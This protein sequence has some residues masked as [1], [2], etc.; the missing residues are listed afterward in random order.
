MLAQTDVTASYIGDVTW[1][2][3]GGGHSHSSSNHQESNGIGWWNNQTLP[4]GWHA[5]AAP[6]TTGG[7]G[8]SWTPGF[9]GA[10]V[11]MG[12][13]MVLPAGEYTLSFEAFACNATNSSDPATLPAA[14][15]A[16][17]FLTGESNIDITNTAAAGDATFHTAS[18]TF[19]VATDNTAYEFGIKKLADDSKIDWC[20]IK[21]VTLTLN[22]TDK[23]AIPNNDIASFTYS[24]SQTWHTNT[25]STEGQSDGSRFQVPFHELWVASGSKLADATITGS[26]TPTTTGVYKISAWVRAVNELG[27]AVTGV[28]IFVGDAESDA[29]S[30]SS[31]MDGKGRLGTYT[32]MA[33]GV[34]GTPIEYGFKI[35]DA[36]VNWLAFKN[37]V[38]TYLGS[39]PTDEVNALLDA[40]PTG[41][42]NADVQTALTTAVSNLTS[43]QSVANYN[44]LSTAISNA[45]ASI[46]IY[47][48]VAGYNT[49]V[50]GLSTEAQGV[51]ADMLTAYTNGTITDLAPA[52]TAYEYAVN[53]DKFVFE[54]NRA[55]ALGVDAATVNVYSTTNSAE[56]IA[57][58]KSLM[59]DEYSSVTTNYSYA[60]DL[61]TWTTTNAVERNGQHWDGTDGSKY[62]EQNVG[63]GDD[64]WS[65]S[66]TQDLSL[67]AGKYVFKVAGRKSFDDASLT[68]VVSN[69]GTELG[70]VSD[71]PNGDTGLGINTSGA[72]DFDPADAYA[73]S[74]NGRGWQWRY[75]QFELAEPATVT[76]AINGS[77]TKKYN[78]VGFCNATVQTDN[79]ANVELM[80]ALV[81]LNS[82]KTAATLTK[83]TANVGTGVFKYDGTTNESLWSAYSTAKS[84]ADAYTLTSSSTASEVN[85]LAVALNTAITN[86]NNQTLNAPADTRYNV[87]IVEAGKD[88]NG[89]AI[90]FIEGGRADQGLYGV[91]YYTAAN[92]NYNQAL[93]FTATGTPDTY[94]ISALRPDGTEQYLT[95]G[96]TY[97]GN[98]DQIR[99]TNDASAAMLV[100]I[101]A[102]ATDG[103]FQLYNVAAGKVI[104]NN[105][106]ND[107]Y[108]ANSASF[109]IAE[110]TQASAILKANAGKFG[111]FIAPFAVTI[112]TGIEA[113]KVTTVTDGKLTLEAVTTT[114]PANTAVVVKNTSG[115]DYNETKQGWGTAKAD[116]YVTELL[117]GVYTA[118]DIPVSD[119]TTTNYVLQTD[120]DT[121]AFY[122]VDG[123]FIATPNR[124]Y[125]TVTTGGGAKAR[126]LYFDEA[127]AIENLT[128]K[129]EATEGTIYNLNGQRVNTLQ[130]GINIVGGTKVLVK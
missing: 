118:A 81:A 91:Q 90:T 59:V 127:T 98:N 92:A 126:V 125:L 27:G 16:V 14:G 95:T 84:N 38:I 110:A 114:I 18:F 39:L 72:T 8:E 108:T 115:S 29:C 13:T 111:T 60:V 2:V 69:G 43:V 6:N 25:W 19:T 103:Q 5:F 11:M 57:N 61:G 80:E 3:N 53:Y 70:T 122:V 63:W 7:A 12:R 89:N 113:Y 47:S 15:D 65:C 112:P 32:A 107:M 35:K 54:K 116:S 105:N 74:N 40:V 128:E 44:A 109:T 17:A 83:R 82:A 31:V 71:F 26:Y 45:N 101:I 68:L 49:A 102:T 41:K 93:K 86:Y 34:D 88:W 36:E 76:V 42:M 50:A 121:Q 106:N 4:S 62:S 96:T 30:G 120:G 119:G 123:A 117:T 20:Q 73:N 37:V 67:P 78:W 51:Y 24:G 66:Y 1:I 75:V 85:A 55:L 52:T 28:K 104:A 9:G 56:A 58:I 99:T 77:A 21:N 130:R 124:C 22:S 129:T 87:T 100:K 23:V 97:G 10:G 33:D 48:I 46:G 79:A 64:S 94:K